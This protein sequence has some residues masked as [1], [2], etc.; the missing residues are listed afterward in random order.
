[1]EEFKI[2][3]I[4]VHKRNGKIYQIYSVYPGDD[5]RYDL[6]RFNNDGMRCTRIYISSDDIRLADNDEISEFCRLKASHETSE[7]LKEKE[8]KEM[9]SYKVGD[10]VDH[11]LYNESM[12]VDIS[13]FEKGYVDIV[14][15]TGMS[16]GRTK[17]VSIDNIKQA[18]SKLIISIDNYNEMAN[19]IENLK[20]ENIKLKE[21]AVTIVHEKWNLK[22]ENK[23]LRKE[24]T[25]MQE[26]LYNT[27]FGYNDYK[28]PEVKE[29]LYHKP[30]T[31]IFWKD[32]TKTVVKTQNKEKYDKEKGF[33]M[34]YLKKILGNEGN[35]YE[36]IKRWTDTQ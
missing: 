2:G 4:V 9:T 10:I 3:D 32:G 27:L 31:I 29:V 15:L 36:V 7:K 34:A 18:D 19:T 16:R 12:I 11:P 13:E 33:V 8:T 30:A 22:S 17:L 5:N 25:E 35:Y 1:M 6:E 24:K 26:R 20:K 21:D 28:L 23:H 14:P